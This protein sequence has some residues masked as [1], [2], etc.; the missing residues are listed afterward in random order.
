MQ[1]KLLV[2]SLFS[3][4]LSNFFLFLL[5]PKLERYFLTKPNIRSSHSLPTP[6][7]GGIV[8]V[9]IYCF[10][11]L[12]FGIKLPLLYLPLAFI[13][14]LDDLFDLNRFFRYLM[15]VATS[16]LMIY[17]SNFYKSYLLDTDTLIF[18]LMFI[19]LIL[20]ITAIINF[21]NF[22]DGIDGIVSSCLIIVFS[23]IS[24]LVNPYLLILVG[25]LFGFLFWN[26]HPSKIFMGDVG[27]TFLGA[28]LAGTLI[29][30]Y[31]FD[32]FL[33]IILV[34]SPLL[35]DSF[36]CVLRRYYAKEPIFKS[37]S[38]HLY[39]RLFQAG[40][41]HSKVTTLYFLS[42]LFLALLSI[43]GNFTFMIIGLISIFTF[44]IFLDFN[45]AIPFK[46][47]LEKNKK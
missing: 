3:F 13:G 8:F 26:W 47:S 24:I 16:C 42:T 2:F 37:H 38:L 15:Q 17:E 41:S 25:A 19:F 1:L 21:I 6:S 28:V 39:Q 40:W 18:I 32:N 30:Q 22:M 27:S 12:I 44:G 43:I 46:I 23:V 34:A 35:L 9:L 31:E 4:V 45:Y 33:K 7:G 20:F 36:I 14:F 10:G 5:K 11:A 29:N